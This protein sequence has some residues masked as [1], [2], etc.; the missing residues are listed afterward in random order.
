VPAVSHQANR[1]AP[2][3]VSFTNGPLSSIKARRILSRRALVAEQKLRVQMLDVDAAILPVLEGVLVRHQSARGFVRIGEELTVVYFMVGLRPLSPGAQPT[4][5][6]RI[7]RRT[8]R[9]RQ[10]KTKPDQPPDV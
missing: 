9:V 2:L 4:R 3:C 6:S 7:Q 5:P 1:S 10:Q 8:Q